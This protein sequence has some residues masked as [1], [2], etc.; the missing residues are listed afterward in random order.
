MLTD[1]TIKAI[2]PTTKP[3]KISDHS[4][5]GLTL[6]VQPI[7]STGR[8][9]AK[10]FMW[11]GRVGGKVKL[12][13]IG[14]YPVVRL[15]EARIKAIE[16]SS[17]IQRGE[18]TDKPE[19]QR[20][21][22]VDAAF[23]A[24]MEKEGDSRKSAFEKWRVYCR[25]V[26]PFIGHKMMHTITPRMLADI[27]N[28]KA[29]SAPAGANHL[30]ALLSRFFNWSASSKGWADSSITVSPMM[31]VSKPSKTKVRE[32]VLSEREIRW[33]LQACR[34]LQ[35]APR[36]NGLRSPS[37]SHWA[38][39]VE[40]L[41]RTGQRRSDV[42]NLTH[43]EIDGNIATLEGYRHKSGGTHKFWLTDDSLSLVEK[44]GKHR[45]NPKVF[46][47]SGN[48]ETHI[49][50]IRKRVKE[51]AKREKGKVEHWTLHDLRRTVATTLADMIDDDERPVASTDE[52]KK[53]LGH[54]LQ[55]A[56]AHYLHGH[57]LPMKKRLMGVW[58]EWLNSRLEHLRLVA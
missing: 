34:E 40:M 48:E 51:V 35:D 21:V 37:T 42:L 58:N 29:K 17:R 13:K 38:L 3:Q 11:R 46:L 2:Q 8:P 18:S 52:I 36:Y 6:V 16:I 14:R 53:L 31:G 55:G 50:R 12:V 28:E 19:P 45:L 25:D 32:R 1:A 7:T 41:L 30:Q 44:A 27:I 49:Q 9:S 57:A 54:T 4:G 33:V 23:N 10:T 20:H 15:A 43:D 47:C 39:V 26:K 22:T 24:Y 5:S 56:I